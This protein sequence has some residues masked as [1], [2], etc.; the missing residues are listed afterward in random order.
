MKI[1]LVDDEHY[2]LDEMERLCLDFGKRCHLHI[3]TVLFDSGEA[4][5]DA[6]ED[7]GFSI[8]FMDIYMKGTDGVEIALK[9]R[10]QDS[11]CKLIFLTSA[12]E[13][14]PDAFSCHAF[15]YIT[16]PFSPQRISQVLEDALKV[17]PTLYRYMEVYSGQKT[18]RIFFNN[19]IF[20]ITDA[21]Y[22]EI[23]LTDGTTVR[24]RMTMNEFMELT[25]G[26]DR[27]IH[28]NKGIT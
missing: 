22:L 3:E 23:K 13:F 18:V 2:Y 9:M 26:D 19:I 8:V 25:D 1:A 28:A 20:I 17:L 16:K 12:T 21:H 11:G 15:E 10:K 24:C 14:M 27:F 5:L 7:G 6:F 4:F